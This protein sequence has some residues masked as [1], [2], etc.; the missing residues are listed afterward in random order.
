MPMHDLVVAEAMRWDESG[1]PTDAYAAV[2]S[3]GRLQYPLMKL[4]TQGGPGKP[5]STARH[6]QPM[7]APEMW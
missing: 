5:L 6:S 2:E 4:Y 7:N 3:F 1:A